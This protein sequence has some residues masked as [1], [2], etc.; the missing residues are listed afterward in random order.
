MRPKSQQGHPRTAPDTL[1]EPSVLSVPSQKTTWYL[2]RTAQGPPKGHPR[3]HRGPAR[4]PS[5]RPQ[6]PKGPNEPP[7]IS[8]KVAKRTRIQNSSRQT[9]LKDYL[10]AYLGSSRVQKGTRYQK[11][12]NTTTKQNGQVRNGRS[13]RI[14]R[15]NM[16]LCF[17]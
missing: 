12:K 15:L 17:L 10:V 4:M 11:S 16:F 2:Q 8:T 14:P 5:G 1:R 6:T 9:S 7:K 3:H 13:T